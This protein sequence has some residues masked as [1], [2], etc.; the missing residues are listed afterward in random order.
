[1]LSQALN[2]LVHIGNKKNLI[3]QPFESHAV[4]PL[5]QSCHL[6]RP[7][8]SIIQKGSLLFN[9]ELYPFVWCYHCTVFF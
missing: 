7:P 3:T 2:I 9:I 5:F 6:K 8:C 1:M 4:N